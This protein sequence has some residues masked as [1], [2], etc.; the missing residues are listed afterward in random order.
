MSKADKY[1]QEHT[2]ALKE[3]N[4]K[5]YFMWI[6]PDQARRAVEIAREEIYEWLKEYVYIYTDDLYLEGLIRDLKQAIKDE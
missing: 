2:K 5:E 1:I 6:T 3:S 4:G